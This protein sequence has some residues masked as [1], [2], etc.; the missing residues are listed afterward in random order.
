MTKMVV[1]AQFSFPLD[2][3]IAKANLAS[4]GIA[5]LVADEQQLACSGDTQCNGWCNGRRRALPTS[6]KLN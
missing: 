4:I 2:A 3:N 5:S 1:L 6:E